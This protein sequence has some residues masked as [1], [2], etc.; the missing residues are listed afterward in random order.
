MA[1]ACGSC[2]VGDGKGHP[3]FNLTR[4]GR[5]V[6]GVFDPM[7]V[8]GRTPGAEPGRPALRGGGRPDGATGVAV[9]T[10]P[11]VTG[12][13]LLDAVDDT[14]LLRLADP[15]DLDGDG[16]SGRVQ[17]LD[18]SDLIVEVTSLDA[19]ADEGGPT[20]GVPIGGKY[21]GRFGKKG[22]TVNLLHQTV[23][24]YHQDMGLTSDLVP[25]DLFN[26]QVGTFA[27]D[28][29]PIRRSARAP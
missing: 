1:S 9:F 15:D 24:A 22:V 18:E 2:H 26:R 19:V 20:R 29:V 3:V 12:L 16:I 11:A 21:I 25:E 7:R 13:G 5:M 6:D 10:A 27:S 23:T 4:F 28:D 8:A 14:T 17:L